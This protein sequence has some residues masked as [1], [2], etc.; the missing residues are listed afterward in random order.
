M[1][2]PLAACAWEHVSGFDVFASARSHVGVE[3]F[4]QGRGNLRV[5]ATQTRKAWVDWESLF[6]RKRRSGFALAEG[7]H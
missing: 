4:A 1:R 2:L 5:T 6:W 7:F 3:D